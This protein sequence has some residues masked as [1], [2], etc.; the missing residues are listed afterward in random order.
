MPKS[1][2]IVGSYDA[3]LAPC[4]SGRP[5]TKV[6]SKNFDRNFLN[7]FLLDQ[8]RIVTEPASGRETSLACR[9]CKQE[10]HVR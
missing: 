6:R 8:L 10:L 2:I 9:A 7:Y 3:A 4:T 5:F 1:L